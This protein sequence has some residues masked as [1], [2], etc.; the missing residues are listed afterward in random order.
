MTNASSFASGFVKTMKRDYV[1]LMPNL[2]EATAVR[3][4]AVAF[5]QK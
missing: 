4:L 1:A 2:D 5:E 3:D